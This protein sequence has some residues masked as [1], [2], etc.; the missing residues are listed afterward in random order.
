MTDPVNIAD[1]STKHSW[2]C[3]WQD[4]GFIIE[5][6]SRQQGWRSSLSLS[7]ENIIE[8]GLQPHG[9]RFNPKMMIY[10]LSAYQ[11]VDIMIIYIYIYT[12]IYTQYIYIYTQYTMT[13]L[14][15]SYHILSLY[16]TWISHSG[17]K[18]R[19]RLVT[20]KF[21]DPKMVGS[22][23]A[24]WLMWYDIG[25][26]WYPKTGMILVWFNQKMVWN[27]WVWYWLMW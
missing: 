2:I 24:K 11:F 6:G 16:K 23:L 21:W 7:G 26:V 19:L 20:T 13:L 17:P 15:S 3:Q 12:Y 27:T 25:M 22:K 8:I 18:A 10:H 5:R 14:I 9:G 4:I 1:D